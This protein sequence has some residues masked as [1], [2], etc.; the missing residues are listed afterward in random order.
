MKQSKSPTQQNGKGFLAILIA[1]AIVV[2][3]LVAWQTYDAAQD[4][5][6]TEEDQTQSEMQES[7]TTEE[8]PTVNESSDLDAAQ[9]AAEAVNPESLDTQELD[10]ILNN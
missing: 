8:L 4:N 5:A 7:A 3:A 6:G 10:T 2:L 9:D 1:V